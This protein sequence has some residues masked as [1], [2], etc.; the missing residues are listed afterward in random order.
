MTIYFLL[1]ISVAHLSSIDAFKRVMG[2]DSLLEVP[3]AH[4]S[5]IDAFK[6]VMG[7]DSLLLKSKSF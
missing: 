3:V 7:L 4:L 2:L 1:E 5:P 6:R